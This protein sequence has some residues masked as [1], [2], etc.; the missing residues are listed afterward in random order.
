MMSTK[1]ATP[2]ILK[3]MVFRNKGY[4]L[5]ISANDVASKILSRDS[6]FIVDKFMW[7]KV[8]NS[9]IFMREVITT[10]IL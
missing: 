8:G 6:N 10:L 4:D 7:S 1:T 9:S 5:I 2:G 3:I